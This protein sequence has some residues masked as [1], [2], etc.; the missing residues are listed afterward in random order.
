MAYT[1]AVP[2][3]VIMRHWNRKAEQQ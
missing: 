1:T 3:A 2:T